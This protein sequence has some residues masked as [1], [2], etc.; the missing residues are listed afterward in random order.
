MKPLLSLSPPRM[1]G[2]LPADFP[3]RES[4]CCSFVQQAISIMG[5]LS[6]VL[7]TDEA[8]FGHDGII[9]LHHHLWTTDSPHGIV[10]TSHQQRFC[11]NMWAGII[12]DRL[13]GPVLLPQHLNGETYLAFL[14]NTLP[15]LLENVPLAIRQ[16]MWLQHD[17]APAHFR[18][19]VR[20]HLKNIFPR[21]CIGLG[22]T[23]KWPAWSLDLNPLVFYLWGIWK[24]LCTVSLFLMFR[25]FDSVST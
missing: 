3:P 7:F 23:V 22:G 5:L 18:I 17:G 1:Q 14:Q 24:A 9:N 11:I 20:R 6:S 21:R 10:E 15:P 13:L 25:P 2:L 8:I 12:G 4:F 16:T 19:N